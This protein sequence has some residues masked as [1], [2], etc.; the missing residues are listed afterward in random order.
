MRGVSAKADLLKFG[1]VVHPSV[2]PDSGN[3]FWSE[4]NPS[5]GFGVR[6]LPF[7]F[8][9]A[10]EFFRFDLSAEYDPWLESGNGRALWTHPAG[11]IGDRGILLQ[12]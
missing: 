1:R 10:E 12:R 2:T 11:L 4:Y 3:R 5:Y 6:F 7:P 8:F 9:E